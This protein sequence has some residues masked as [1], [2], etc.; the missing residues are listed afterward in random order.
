MLKLDRNAVI[1]DLAETYHVYDL[2]SLPLETVAILVCGLREN[3]RIKQKISGVK[4]PTEILLLAHAV[5]RL[6]LLIWQNGH[7]KR[8]KPESIVELIAGAEDKQHIA[9]DSF[10]SAEAFEQ[11]RESLIGRR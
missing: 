9:V 4:A 11:Y 6:G 7:R 10:E 1:C 8:N 3:S 2:E 5:D